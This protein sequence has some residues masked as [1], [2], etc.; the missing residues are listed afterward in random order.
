LWNPKVP[1]R[2]YKSSPPIPIQSQ[3]NPVHNTQS[4]IYL[5]N[6]NLKCYFTCAGSA[7]LILFSKVNLYPLHKLKNCSYIFACAFTFVQS[8]I[9]I[10]LWIHSCSCSCCILRMCGS[11]GIVWV[12][13]GGSL[14]SCLLGRLLLI[15]IYSQQQVTL[16][17]RNNSVRY[18]IFK[19]L[20]Q[21]Q[22][23][24]NLLRMVFLWK[25]VKQVCKFWVR[26]SPCSK[27]CRLQMLT[28]PII[29]KL[30][31]SL[32]PALAWKSLFWWKNDTLAFLSW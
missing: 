8:F 15:I 28:H 22:L 21:L 26:R 31:L 2:V 9:C 19:M 4:T 16:E 29:R 13:S 27:Q 20:I 30:F 6:W 1:Y 14:L 24:L 12:F 10:C 3:T 5:H 18:N 23:Q 7:N 25:F 11:Q 17:N 32:L